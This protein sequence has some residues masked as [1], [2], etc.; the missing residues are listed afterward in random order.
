MIINKNDIVILKDNNIETIGFIPVSKEIADELDLA[1]EA[2][3]SGHL[4]KEEFIE[5]YGYVPNAFI[6]YGKT[7]EV[8]SDLLL[9]FMESTKLEVSGRFVN[10]Y[11][12]F[13][14]SKFNL[15]YTKTVLHGTALESWKCLIIHTG[16]PKYG[17]I[18]NLKQHEKD[19]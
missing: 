18:I 5:K 3:Y 4:K 6:M 10:S 17:A 19:I 11:K 16:N 14:G 2:Y 9:P 13:C 7:E 15:D 12:C 8:T 1:T